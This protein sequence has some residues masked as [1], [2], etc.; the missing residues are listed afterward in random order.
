MYIANRHMRIYG[1]LRQVNKA[2]YYS[3]TRLMFQTFVI[4][5]DWE[6]QGCDFP[7]IK[8]EELCCNANARYVERLVIK[9]CE[10]TAGPAAYNPGDFA[11]SCKKFALHL[12]Q[13]QSLRSVVLVFF[14]YPYG[15]H[16]MEAGGHIE[17]IIEALQLAQLPKLERLR[18]IYDAASE[19]TSED[20]LLESP[21]PH[22]PPISRGIKSLQS[23]TLD[24]GYSRVT[25][26]QDSSISQILKQGESLEYVD[27][28]GIHKFPR[29]SSTFLHPS[30]PLQFLRLAFTFLPAECLLELRH[31]QNT[32]RDLGLDDVRLSSRSW[33]EVFNLLQQYFRPSQAAGR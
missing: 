28:H 26:R 22:H 2:F 10:R 6:V 19:F 30:A 14:T 5:L 9:C 24:L 12:R 11:G 16:G 18:I 31:F 25:R 4:Q 1:T 17:Q 21:P 8:F 15:R 13:L 23:V 20:G 33:A 3:A 29:S 27:A 32:L 7:F